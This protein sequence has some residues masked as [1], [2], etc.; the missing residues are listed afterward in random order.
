MLPLDPPVQKV[1]EAY[2]RQVIDTVHD[3]PNVL[4]EVANESSGGGSVDEEFARMLGLG[5]VPEWG[6]STEWQYWVINVIKQYENEQ[7]YEKHPVG[8]TM[9]FPVADQTKVNDPLFNSP[10]DWISPGYDDEIFAG[11]GHPMA[12]GSP[13]SRWYD[14][15]PPNDDRKVVIT[16]TDH[17]A[18]GQGDALWAWKSF[19]RGHH[20]IL[21][22]F[23]IIGGMNS[24]DEALEPARHAMGAVLQYAQRMNLIAMEPRNDL[25]STG[26][27]LVNPGEEYL[28]LQ[29][30][31]AA[32]SFTVTLNASSY[33]VEWFSVNHRETKDAGKMTV[34]SSGIISFTAPFAHAGPT[35]L[36]LKRVEH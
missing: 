6:D 13:A 34:E 29:P 28:V 27:A 33:T 10:A 26:Y 36:Y 5:D 3:L 18:P 24:P 16:D 25:S 14:N 32:A 23:G 12:P 22:D 20:P 15:P 30:N 17:Y 4:Y 2:I 7:G 1:Q 9:Q 35:V 8:M 11:G 21:M 31:D 19:L